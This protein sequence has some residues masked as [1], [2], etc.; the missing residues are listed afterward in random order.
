MFDRLVEL[1]F[2]NMTSNKLETL[3]PNI[4]IN[5]KKLKELDISNIN[6]EVLSEWGLHFL[7][8]LTLIKLDRNKFKSFENIQLNIVNLEKIWISLSYLHNKDDIC[9][10]KNITRKFQATV[11]ASFLLIS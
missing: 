8:N 5:L 10:I 1:L 2:L 4:F 9:K 11:I 3:E 6:L 7:D